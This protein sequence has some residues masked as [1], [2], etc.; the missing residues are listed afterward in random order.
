[1]NKAIDWFIVLLPIIVVLV[2]FCIMW[3][4]T[5]PMHFTHVSNARPALPYN[6]GAPY[7]SMIY[8]VELARDH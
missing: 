2:L 3:Y 4:K 6:G 8:P 1:M 5:P 7:G